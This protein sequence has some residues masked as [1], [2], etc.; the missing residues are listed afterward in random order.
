MA[1]I[2]MPATRSGESIASKALAFVERYLGAGYLLDDEQA[3]S[4]D[5]MWAAVAAFLARPF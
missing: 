4:P 2:A 3:G 1:S 5:L